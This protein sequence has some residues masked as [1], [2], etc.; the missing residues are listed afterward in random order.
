MDSIKKIENKKED[1]N[2]ESPKS[3][4]GK[5]LFK[6]GVDFKVRRNLIPR[7][8]AMIAVTGGIGS[9]KTFVLECFEKL[10][11]AV[12]N[13]DKAIHDLLG[14]DGKAFSVVAKLF[15]N[16]VTEEGI[17]RKVISNEVF[18]DSGYLKELEAVL[19]PMVRQ[20]QV[21]FIVK[22]KNS[23]GGSMVFEVPL[24]FE[25]K[26]EKNYDYVVSCVL[27][28]QIQKERVLG[29][30]NMT[31]E[32]F[33]D[34][35]KRQVQDKVR[36]KGSHFIIRTGSNPIDTMEQVRAAVL[37][38]SF[39]KRSTGNKRDRPRHRDDGTVRKERR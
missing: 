6:N 7:N 10:G 20:A 1:K 37:N 39:K 8:N 32:K 17:N 16:A 23:T 24:L 22:T 19:H 27:P 21:E 30:K 5:H 35:L 38:D 11:F 31:E 36:L 34:I 25:N 15:P 9:G 12:F 33:N 18:K 2:R 26:R 29:R 14:K 13:S 4:R 3:D 28:K